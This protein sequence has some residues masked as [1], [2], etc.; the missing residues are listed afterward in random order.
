MSKQ[1]AVAT[2]GE[3]VKGIK[4]F[5]SSPDIEN[6]YRFI[7]ENGLRKEAKAVLELVNVTLNPKAKKKRKPRKKKIQ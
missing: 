3:A 4:N 1:T 2:E 5:R 6:F 7:H